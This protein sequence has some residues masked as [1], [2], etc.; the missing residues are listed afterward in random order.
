MRKM[1]PSGDRLN[2]TPDLVMRADST[3][4]PGHEPR[5]R[6]GPGPSKTVYRLT[7]IWK[8]AWVRRTALVVLPGLTAGLIGWW[9]MTDPVIRAAVAEKRG[10][11][12]ASLAARPEFALRGVRVVGASDALV[13]RIHETV[14]VSDPSSILTADVAAIRA[15]VA[16][17]PRVK[18]AQATLGPDGIL[19]V[20]V[21]ERIPE[22]LWRDRD[23]R[24]WLI[25]RDGVILDPVAARRDHPAL[26][27]VRGEE[28]PQSIDE[29]LAL[30][31]AVPDLH[32]R[33][34]AFVRVGARRWD[35]VLDKQLRILLPEDGAV[36]A[37]RRVMAW[38][39]GEDLLDRGLRIIDMRNPEQPTLRMTG[40]AYETY[41]LHDAVRGQAEEE[42]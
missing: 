16:E 36:A 24:L 25:D 37:L 38:H 11:I 8:K 3:G 28:K 41:K 33:M 2:A 29:A 31:W 21:S 18:A 5:R 4:V 10:E 14:A 7:R 1:T 23:E 19:V 35:V 27:V 32:P 6:P 22:A 40:E 15:N 30:F 26:P 9:A 39:Y 20:Q 17:I 13:A 34:R 12:F 42:T